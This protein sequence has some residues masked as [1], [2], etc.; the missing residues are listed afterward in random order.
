MNTLTVSCSLAQ[1][2]KAAAMNSGLLSERSIWGRPMRVHKHAEHCDHVAGPHSSLDAGSQVLMVVINNDIPDLEEVRRPVEVE[3]ENEGPHLPSS[4]HCDQALQVQCGARLVDFACPHTKP[5]TAREAPR[6]ITPNMD[7]IAVGA[8]PA[9]F[10]ASASV[11]A[12]K[13]GRSLAPK[14]A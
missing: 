11:R 9:T 10:I 3:F 12:G 2:R 14:S 7:T 6:S 8:G 4:T 5:L 13:I 1:R